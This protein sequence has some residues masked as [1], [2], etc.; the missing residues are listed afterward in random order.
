MESCICNQL[1]IQ[2]TLLGRGGWAEDCVEKAAY[3][4]RVAIAAAGL[5]L[6]LALVHGPV[7]VE[8]VAHLAVTRVLLEDVLLLELLLLLQHHARQLEQQSATQHRV[9]GDQQR[10]YCY[11]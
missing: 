1:I 5:E 8:G 9:R 2:V 6:G 4:F 3:N 7:P 11:I 10:G